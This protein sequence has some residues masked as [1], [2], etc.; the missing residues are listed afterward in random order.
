MQKSLWQGSAVR[1]HRHPSRELSPQ[2]EVER[3]ILE[4]AEKIADLF[5]DPITSSK[6][7]AA[8]IDLWSLETAL[9]HIISDAAQSLNFVNPDQASR[10][11]Y[12][13]R[14]KKVTIVDDLVSLFINTIRDAARNMVKID[15]SSPRLM[16]VEVDSSFT[17]LKA[18][19]KEFIQ[20]IYDVLRQ[21]LL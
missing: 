17:G 5:M 21:F 4:A 6:P 2:V 13:F 16:I 1:A 20:V 10:F 15:F 9:S 3:I 11:I 7:L 8:S 12:E 14:R 18:V 19:R